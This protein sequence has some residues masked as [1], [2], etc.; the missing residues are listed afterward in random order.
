[1]ATRRIS[2]VSASA[3]GRSTR[4]VCWSPVAGDRVA[5]RSSPATPGPRSPAPT[6]QGG[7]KGGTKDH[8]EAPK[9]TKIKEQVMPTRMRAIVQR[10]F[11]S[12]EVL[13][14]SEVDRPDRKSTRLNSSH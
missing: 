14:V 7:T 1:M 4:T 2:S 6:S 10:S 9:I 3:Y 11:G 5:W 8:Q 12:P 13:Q